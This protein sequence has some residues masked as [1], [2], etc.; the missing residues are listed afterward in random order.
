MKGNLTKHIKLVHELKGIRGF[1][2]DTCGKSYKTEKILRN[3]IDSVHKMIT[4]S[5]CDMC[6]KDFSTKANLSNHIKMVHQK[7]L[8]ENNVQSLSMISIL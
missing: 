3:H 4:L 5:K 1:K 2:C 6:D 8:H 7:N